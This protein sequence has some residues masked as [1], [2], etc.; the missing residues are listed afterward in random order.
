MIATGGKISYRAKIEIAA[1]CGMPD[2][3]KDLLIKLGSLRNDFA[4]TLAAAISKQAVLNIYNSLSA[5][6]REGLAGSYKAMGIG[7]FSSPSSL[8][9][10]DL[11]ILILINARQAA[12]AATHVLRGAES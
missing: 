1:G 9:S 11:L 8:E 2:D 7:A 10:R 6:L 4:H 5:R 3:L 12:K